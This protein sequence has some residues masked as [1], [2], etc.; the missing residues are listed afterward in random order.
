MKNRVKNMVP[1][2]IFLLLFSWFLHVFNTL[3]RPKRDGYGAMWPEYKMEPAQ[4]IDVMFTGTSIAYCDVIPAVIYEDSGISS[5]VL[6]GP[7]LTMPFTYYYIKEAYQTQT[8][9]LLFV[10]VSAVF[11]DRHMNYTRI[12]AGY[13]PWSW[14]RIGA[15]L[16]ASEREEWL[17]ILFP[18]YNYHD[19][20]NALE[21]EDFMQN[22]SDPLAGYTYLDGAMDCTELVQRDIIQDI[23]TYEENI[24]YLRKIYEFC[25]KKGTKAVFYLAPS[26]SR[27][28]GNAIEKLDEEIMQIT[29][30]ALLE[31]DAI[32]DT[33]GIDDSTDYYDPMHFNVK[34]AVKF[35]NLCKSF[36]QE[37]YP[38]IEANGAETHD[39][40]WKKRISYFR[41][42]S[43]E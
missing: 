33:L 20:W 29:G 13:M 31:F 11:Y 40:L 12:N 25:E 2:L 16:H 37:N 6:A 9:Q 36:I 34:G 10:E 7:E 32:Y 4:S 39:E 41:Q 24:K 35:S 5:Y 38:E 43:A 23:S 28:D 1:F 22:T 30:D 15:M 19:R 21:D 8:P 14:N 17:G 18:P 42:L 26:R 27:L 3:T